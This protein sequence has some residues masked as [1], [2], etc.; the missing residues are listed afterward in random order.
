[1][2]RTTYARTPGARGRIP[3]HQDSWAP[4]VHLDLHRL[5]SADLHA[6]LGQVRVGEIGVLACFPGGREA[7]EPSGHRGLKLAWEIQRTSRL[8]IPWLA[9]RSGCLPFTPR[10]FWHC[11]PP[12]SSGHRRVRR[13]A[14]SRVPGEAMGVIVLHCVAV[15]CCQNRMVLPSV[16][17]TCHGSA[18]ICGL[19]RRCTPR[20]VLAWRPLWRSGQ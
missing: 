15:S 13:G 8:R 2:E 1:M 11:W 4:A 16:G 17:P 7:V 18:S 19:S 6:Q 3:P 12:A 10:R 5:A 20:C 14:A 9:G